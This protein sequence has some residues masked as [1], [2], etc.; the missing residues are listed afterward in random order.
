MADLSALTASDLASLNSLVGQPQGANTPNV[1]Q[2]D[3]SA[4]SSVM[5]ATPGGQGA[6]GISAA[7]MSSLQSQMASLVGTD[8]GAIASDQTFTVGD[9]AQYGWEAPGTTQTVQGPSGDTTQAYGSGAG[10]WA[11]KT[12]GES[13]NALV[14]TSAGTNNWSAGG[15][16]EG[17]VSPSGSMS[18]VAMVGS[19]LGAGALGLGAGT[20]G[21]AATGAGA[22]TAA[23]GTGA[24]LTA[25]GN[26][27]GAG[28]G[29]TL[30]GVDTGVSAGAAGAGAGGAAG[31]GAGG[32]GAGGLFGTGITAGQAI[33]GTSALSG[34]LGSALGGSGTTGLLSNA[35][36]LLAGGLTAAALNNGNSSA[37]A[38]AATANPFQSQ[39]AGY[40]QQ[41]QGLMTNPNSFQQS[42]ESQALTQQGMAQTNAQMG[43]SGLFNSGAQEAA[44]TNLATTNAGTNYNQQVSTLEQL[45]GA[46]TS[47]PATAGQILQN[48]NAANTKSAAATGSAVGSLVG[49]AL[50]GGATSGLNSLVNGGLTN[51]NT[52]NVPGEGTN[53]VLN[54]SGTGTA[55]A[56][57]PTPAPTTALGSGNWGGDLNSLLGSSY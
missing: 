32:G 30:A 1:D 9:G 16:F 18:P 57:A 26:T 49:S 43:A 23:G 33:S 13:N 19:V 20:A 27:L 39:Y 34:L 25:G 54:G 50:G 5:D 56:A 17:A 15:S 52:S 14:D 55:A 24:G 42:A 3:I 12:G 28:L 8:P 40:Q 31:A 29:N 51:G 48:Q 22:G 35:G 46:N 53:S 47:S 10:G 2:A 38:A 37:Q 4:F 21:T 41:L 7:D 44:L 36:G 11:V 45:S 6:N